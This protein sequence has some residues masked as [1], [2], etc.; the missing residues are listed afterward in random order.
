MNIEEYYDKLEKE[1]KGKSFAFLAERVEKSDENPYG[2]A[3]AKPI[4]PDDVVVLCLAGNGGRGKHFK[5]YNG[6]L[7]KVDNFIKQQKDFDGKKV[8]VCVAI[9]DI[10]KYHRP[11]LA[12]DLFYYKAWGDQEY[13]D[14]DLREVS[15]IA[16]EE[17]LNPQY[18]KDIYDLVIK[19]KVDAG[20]TDLKSMRYYMRTFTTVSH[21]HGGYVNLSMEEMLD[22]DLSEKGFNKLEK[23]LIFKR[24]F[25]V[26]YSPECPVSI[27]KSN[28]VCIES[29]QDD[30]A[31]YQ[32]PL[33]EYFQMNHS[34]FGL[35][36][37]PARKNTRVF[38]CAKIDKAG[39]EGNPKRKQELLR[40]EFG[41]KYYGYK[42]V[43]P[44]DIGEH[45]FL[46]FEKVKN[47]SKGAIKLQ[48]FANN[49]LCGSVRNSLKQTK[50]KLSLTPNVMRL[51]SETP[52][53]FAEFVKAF[54]KGQKEIIKCQF[55]DK[56]LLNSFIEWHQNFRISK[57][58][59]M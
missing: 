8:R 47:M 33:K 22:N 42:D 10:G 48:R 32:S 52:K 21:C 17:N 2:I 20:G 50:D 6:F 11:K 13:I 31:Q 39:V 54:I 24:I 36:M 15:E 5:E 43:D 19:P 41:V 37:F 46:G 45:D 58:D 40:E 14:D 38:M 27:A 57:E 1:R 9:C 29:A 26:N 12:R 25:S 49:V 44:N 18:I 35:I 30:H 51:A 34:D 59:D 53:Q 23:D 4:E 3:V 7:K 55:T 16:K 56:E 28:F